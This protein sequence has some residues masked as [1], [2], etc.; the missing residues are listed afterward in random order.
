M[1]FKPAA[2]RKFARGAWAAGVCAS[3][4]L[5]APSV[6]NAQTSTERVLKDG[7][8]TIGIFNQS[9]WGYVGNDGKAAGIGPDMIAAVLGPIGVKKVD[10]VVMDLG[11]LIPSLLARRIDAVASGLAITEQRCQ[12]VIFTNP[13]VVVGDGVVVLSG[14]PHNIHSYANI[15]ANPSLTLG[16]QRGSSNTANAKL[17]GVPRDRLLEFPDTHS[18]LAALLSGRTA[19]DTESIATAIKVTSDPALKGKIELARPFKG[20]ILA[21]GIEA[22]NYA[23][24]AFRKEDLELRNAYNRSQEKVRNEGT[25]RKILDRNGLA[26]AP[27][28]PPNVTPHKLF[29]SCL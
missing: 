22:A 19:A 2:G 10:F 23:A 29:S 1:R 6:S 8:I 17:A 18:G 27:L 11:A 26:D 14:N 4:I 24:I 28:A 21:N 5:L 13:D 25:L 3:A 7:H 15:V 16:G 12:Q 20:A 9:P